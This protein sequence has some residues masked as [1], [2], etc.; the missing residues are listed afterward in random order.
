MFHAR[1]QIVLSEG[2]LL[3]ASNV[4]F[5]SRKRDPNIIIGLPAK[6]R[7]PGGPMMALHWRLAWWLCNIAG[8]SDQY[9][10][11]T[12]YFV[13]SRGSRPPVPHPLW[14]RQFISCIPKLPLPPPTFVFLSM[15][16]LT[17]VPQ[18]ILEGHIIRYGILF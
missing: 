2:V 17:L 5:S 14:I 4:F 12:L 15:K 7:F 9:C 18:N 1:I 6:R 3:N 8:D 10:Y 16:W 11:E 13:I